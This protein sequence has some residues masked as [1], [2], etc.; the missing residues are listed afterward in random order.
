MTQIN[1]QLNSMVARHDALQREAIATAAQLRDEL[2]RARASA[3]ITA[4]ELEQALTSQAERLEEQS[5]QLD[6]QKAQ[7]RE[8]TRENA[9][10][11]AE[12]NDASNRSMAGDEELTGLRDQLAAEQAAKDAA[13]DDAGQ[14]RLV[15]VASAADKLAL[16]EQIGQL[17]QQNEQLGGAINK[18]Q[19]EIEDR[20]VELQ[21]ALAES[22]ERG[23]NIAAMFKASSGLQMKIATLQDNNVQLTDELAAAVAKL[24]ESEALRD[25]LQ[26][27]L[28]AATQALRAELATTREEHAAALA[29]AKEGHAAELAAARAEHA[30][31]SGGLQ[32]GHA[33]TT[34]ALK[35]ELAST[36]SE[37][38]A[39]QAAIAEASQDAVASKARIVELESV[40]E[41][42]A[43]VHS[44]RV[45]AFHADIERLTEELNV[46][47][48]ALQKAT[49]KL[50]DSKAEINALQ[51]AQTLQRNLFQSARE[52]ISRA[53]AD[54]A[55][56][57]EELARV[58]AELAAA[59]GQRES[60]LAEHQATLES[61]AAAAAKS[62]EDA[63]NLTALRAEHA[64]L[65]GKHLELEAQHTEL[66]ARHEELRSESESRNT[67]LRIK[68][69]EGDQTICEL[70]AGIA[71]ASS[72]S[73]DAVDA[74]DSVT[75]LTRGIAALEVE[76]DALDEQ[77]E[78]LKQQLE[79][80]TNRAEE[81]DRS[82]AVLEGR[83]RVSEDTLAAAQQEVDRLAKAMQ[84]ERD[85]SDGDKR[86]LTAALAAAEQRQ[87]DESS[88]LS[89]LMQELRAAQSE[90][91]AAQQQLN[92]AAD[93]AEEIKRVQ[94][95]LMK[96]QAQLD[97][98][99]QATPEVLTIGDVNSIAKLR[100]ERKDAELNDARTRFVQQTSIMHQ[101]EFTHADAL[102]AAEDKLAA[103]MRRQKADIGDQDSK[104]NEE[105]SQLTAQISALK[106]D[107]AAH[108][109]AISA[110]ERALMDSAAEIYRHKTRSEE[111][112]LLV[113]KGNTA[114]KPL[115]PAA[116][117][118]IKSR[119]IIDDD[120]D[121]DDDLKA[122]LATMVGE[123]GRLKGCL[124]VLTAEVLRC[125][126]IARENDVLGT[127]L[128]AVTSEKDLLWDA[129]DRTISRRSG[130][131]TPPASPKQT[132]VI[133]FR[134]MR[135]LQTALANRLD[136]PDSITLSIS[137]S[138]LSLADENGTEIQSWPLTH[139]KRFGM[140]REVCTFEL[141]HVSDV[142]G[143]IHLD[144]GRQAKRLF[145]SIAV[146]LG[147]WIQKPQRQR[148][149]AARP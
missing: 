5:S 148:A 10:M 25:A 129:L 45:T 135:P 49:A 131:L 100:L 19:Q 53:E 75:K 23:Q 90:L 14:Q 133:R 142:S 127:R 98:N 64:H 141:G 139:L 68:L 62:A 30:L 123:H 17:A 112:G 42:Q 74:A 104:F 67:M 120:G 52:R 87:R 38:E 56:S 93:S 119:A 4:E 85:G 136:L 31:A 58:Q 140:E 128:E 118:E 47:E 89:Q 138:T 116:P 36:K 27:E 28:A 147:P 88:R 92:L 8:L 63:T 121:V 97:V 60:L 41:G 57:V 103:T 55:A 2:D 76:R 54:R 106:S 82:R 110:K 12:V 143:V 73:V 149:T 13:L 105:R 59:K 86:L 48:G 20:G 125:R 114:A 33:T 37:L 66:A 39:A 108:Q 130:R 145:R 77:S 69:T 32:A 18:L 44:S 11:A 122:Q 101:M 35:I 94:A 113:T 109:V 9:Q 29:A 61:A 99:R 84:A 81:A 46:S 80:S 72:A 102:N 79:Q 7:L 124:R 24:D 40:L 115:A 146:N 70:R 91:L 26:T 22:D 117:V 6:D 132:Q 21:V 71:S 134:G 126:A 3:V 144:A 43:S 50:E 111:L 16:A 107:V 137:N 34:D 65:Q 78:L 15:A 96:L 95:I 83:I 51:T 1:D